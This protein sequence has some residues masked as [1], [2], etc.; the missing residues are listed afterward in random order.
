MHGPAVIIIPPP[1][2]GAAERRAGAPSTDGVG[3]Q[4][5]TSSTK[6]TRD[7][8]MAQS[9]YEQRDEE[10]SRAAH[11][12]PAQT[13]TEKHAKMGGYI[14]SI[15]Y[16]GLDGIITTFAVVAGAAGGGLGPNVVIVM[17][18][19]SLLADA[20][21]MGVGDALS[22]KAETEVARRERER[23]VWELEN[24]KEGEVKEMVEIYMKRGMNLQD[25][26]Q[27]LAS[28]RA[29][30]PPPSHCSLHPGR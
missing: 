13:N 3:G 27:V 29:V 16:G 6:T 23:E 25:A 10:A 4:S 1:A 14:K 28:G 30:P 17:G 2:L 18:I 21:S 8:E 5:M 15:V 22:S 7:L 20:L 19:S 9:A 12:A 26:E 24:F 11:E